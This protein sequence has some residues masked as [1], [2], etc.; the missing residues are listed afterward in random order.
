MTV[1]TRATLGGLRRA[2]EAW[3]I[4]PAAGLSAAVA[5]L[6]LR[7]TFLVVIV[8]PAVAVLVEI[9]R[10]ILASVVERHW[11]K[12]SL[13]DI[14][15]S[16]DALSL[17]LSGPLL[18]LL[19]LAVLVRVYLMIDF[20]IERFARLAFNCDGRDLGA[21]LD[22]P[23]VL[24]LRDFRRDDEII[25]SGALEPYE[26]PTFLTE[27]EPRLPPLTPVGST[28]M[29]VANL[30]V[31]S[32]ELIL[33]W[34][35]LKTW[36][37]EETIAAALPPGAGFL[38]IGRPGERLPASGAV[39]LYA[40]EEIWQDA[41]LE[42][43]A[44]ARLVILRM[45]RSKGLSWEIDQVLGAH[46]GADL[47]L[48]TVDDQGQPMSSAEVRAML[49]RWLG[50]DALTGLDGL[51]YVQG[52]S[53]R[54]NGDSSAARTFAFFGETRIEYLRS[55]SRAYV[56]GDTTRLMHRLLRDSDD[57]LRAGTQREE[58]HRTSVF[59]ALGGY[60]GMWLTA[61]AAAGL[62][63]AVVSPKLPTQGPALLEHIMSAFARLVT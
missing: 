10:R 49:G 44:R 41:V 28:R 48:L 53:S 30:A 38:A 12:H 60:L 11:R 63:I 31:I 37:I 26:G 20:R 32:H 18:S 29:L 40:W 9:N 43:I 62:A 3:W 33:A 21:L 42:L 50:A 16:V 58:P 2:R 39:R 35:R 46:A 15:N 54:A 4:S 24:Y 23:F 27:S 45:G 19:A 7:V 47:I 25:N 34:K 55:G 13:Y 51:L 61:L 56:A 59:R 36:S 52:V 5:L 8:V 14:L 6:L 1:D 57:R 17:L 22:R